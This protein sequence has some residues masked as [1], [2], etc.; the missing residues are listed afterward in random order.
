MHAAAA[1][2][3]SARGGGLDAAL[4]ALLRV[5][6]CEGSASR[7]D[8]LESLVGFIQASLLTS[9]STPA[10]PSSDAAETTS[11]AIRR[12]ARLAGV[13]AGCDKAVHVLAGTKAWLA[14]CLASLP[15]T[16]FQPVVPRDALTQSQAAALQG[17]DTRLSADY[18][19]RRAALLARTRL[20]LQAM[21]AAPRVGEEDST[22]RVEAIAAQLSQWDAAPEVSMERLFT[23]THGTCC[24]I[25]WTT[26]MTTPCTGQCLSLDPSQRLDKQGP[27]SFVRHV[28]IADVPDRG[29]RG[30]ARKGSAPP[31]KGALSDAQYPND[32]NPLTVANAS[33]SKRLAT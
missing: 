11:A 23:L 1:T 16:F 15:P 32:N 7:I 21:A 25:Q 17:V 3:A 24:C 19:Q 22:G 5:L 20:A 2:D 10:M 27:S 4:E 29:G 12:M 28:R 26:G 33:S 9:S 31:A 6:G 30:D 14:P 13:D 18:T 8:V